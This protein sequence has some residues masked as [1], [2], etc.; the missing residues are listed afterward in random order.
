[1]KLTIHCTTLTN[2]VVIE[3]KVC[4]KGPWMVKITWDQ[5]KLQ[6]MTKQTNKTKTKNYKRICVNI[7]YKISN[8]GKAL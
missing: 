4:L 7:D 6:Q 1:M 3:T 5:T 2:F 8:F